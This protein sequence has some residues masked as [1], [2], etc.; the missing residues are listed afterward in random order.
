MLRVCLAGQSSPALIFS[1]TTGDQA[2][3]K[4]GIIWKPTF[5][6]NQFSN[7]YKKVFIIESDGLF[8]VIENDESLRIVGSF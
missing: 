3:E 6:I 4:V 1:R 5:L 7:V 2:F 8:E